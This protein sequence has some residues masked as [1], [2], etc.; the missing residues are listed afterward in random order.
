MRLGI[1]IRQAHEC[2]KHV[3]KQVKMETEQ[4]K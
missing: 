1:G 4:G 3:L 2:P